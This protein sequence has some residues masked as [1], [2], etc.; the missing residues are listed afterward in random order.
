M[1]VDT[2]G[3]AGSA[4]AAAA[5]YLPPPPRS[6][7]VNAGGDDDAT[8]VWRTLRA[9][10]R[11]EGVLVRGL[12]QL[13]RTCR[14]PDEAVPVCADRRRLIERRGSADDRDDEYTGDC[15]LSAVD[16]SWQRECQ[17]ERQAGVHR[18][19]GVYRE[20]VAGEAVLAARRQK[21]MSQV[22]ER[23][24]RTGPPQL[25]RSCL[26]VRVWCEDGDQIRPDE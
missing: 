10:V 26:E 23:W 11:S 4:A 12:R 5:T 7:A 15:E 24:N 6:G 1:E 9:A 8:N 3:A 14:A 13:H 21:K 25:L 20:D 19:G 2:S 16:A 17:R 18:S 22:R